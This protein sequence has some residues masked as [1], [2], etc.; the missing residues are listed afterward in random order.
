MISRTYSTEQIVLSSESS[1]YLAK[2]SHN[3]SRVNISRGKMSANFE[4]PY[5][6]KKYS[7]L[8]ILRQYWQH[9]IKII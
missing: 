6:T 5:A 7:S 2:L 4:K 9:L 8:T 1:R 3:I